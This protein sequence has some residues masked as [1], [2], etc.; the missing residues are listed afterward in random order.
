MFMRRSRSVIIGGKSVIVDRDHLDLASELQ[1]L[2]NLRD[3]VIVR[4][5]PL[6]YDVVSAGAVRSQ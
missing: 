2:D 4:C 5:E 1:A 6:I 3:D